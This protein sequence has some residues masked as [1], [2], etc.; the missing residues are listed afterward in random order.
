V[1]RVLRGGAV[2]G[3]IVGSYR[4]LST[5]GEGGMGSVFLGEHVSI[6]R[7]AAIKVL[8]P[9]VA[10][11][12][13]VVQRFFNEARAANLV[14]HPSIVAVYDHGQSPE[15]GAFLVME[16]LEGES[17]GSRLRRGGVLDPAELAYLL[18]R[19]ASPLAAAHARG[20]VHRDL[21]PDNLFLL[22]DPDHPGE[23]R[24]KILDFGIA[25]LSEP[26]TSGVRTQ[27]GTLLGTP[28]YMSPEQCHGARTVDH[29]TDVYALGVIAFEAVVG[30]VPF[31][32]EGFGVI[33]AAH[34]HE[35]PPS[36]RSFRPELPEALERAILRALAKAPADR[37]RSV[38]ELA[39][40]VRAAAGAVRW[41]SLAPPPREAAE[42]AAVPATL[43]A[44]KDPRDAPP[45]APAIPPT[46]VRPSSEVASS[47]RPRRSRS[48][49]LFALVIVIALGGTTAALL[50][51]RAPAT[52]AT[53][54]APPATTRT[55]PALAQADARPPASAPSRGACGALGPAA[56]TEDALA[57]KT[58][59]G[60][61]LPRFEAACAAGHA[62]GCNALGILV[63]HAD[64]SQRDLARARREFERA[65]AA[66]YAPACVNLG[67]HLATHPPHDRA[68]AMQLLG[69]GC[70]DKVREACFVLGRLQQEAGDR[71][72]ARR[73][74]TRA[75]EL[76]HRAACRAR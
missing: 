23:E 2:I 64:G 58:E 28:Y 11:N 46:A 76:G 44:G 6:G 40:E 41:R 59:L 47:P 14:A 73:S 48:L 69:A 72:G 21:K 8:R 39:Q 67:L 61:A 31:L 38:E 75:C 19:A 5:L 65:C 26:G 9:E 55:T 68:R 66:R 12:P 13:E 51:L 54:S 36:P 70:A 25:K 52:S 18:E 3:A 60:Y 42:E 50:L 49:F 57:R 1:R 32:G 27:T 33:L 17:L 45:A 7:R 24:I 53:T 43:A 4:I 34:L 20:I 22:P 30:R 63:W 15:A 62:K 74:W 10:G 37:Q 56:C 71:A 16:L 35:P 29:R